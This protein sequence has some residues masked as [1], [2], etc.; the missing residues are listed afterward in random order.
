MLH[1]EVYRA[2]TISFHIRKPLQDEA[3]LKSLLGKLLR[4]QSFC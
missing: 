4:S 2:L 3:L 1:F